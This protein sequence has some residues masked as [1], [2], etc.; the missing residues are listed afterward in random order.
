VD[1]PPQYT[2]VDEIQVETTEGVRWEVALDLLAGGGVVVYRGVGMTL[3]EALPHGRSRIGDVFRVEVRSTWE[4]MTQDRARADLAGAHE[5]VRELFQSRAE[6]ALIV[7]ERPALFE[8]VGGDEKGWFTV[9]TETD[10][11]LK[12]S[13][14]FGPQGRSTS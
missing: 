10:D 6:F 14:G 13:P 8:I 3:S 11:V 7:A 1:A 5:V 4:R 2:R 12:W 9:A